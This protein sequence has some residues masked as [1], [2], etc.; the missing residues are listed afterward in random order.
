MKIRHKIAGV[1]L[2]FTLLFGIGVGSST[3]AKAQYPNDRNAQD[4]RDRNNR[5]SDRNRNDNG[6][7]IR[8]G[9][10]WDGYPNLGGTFQ[11]RQTAL[12]AGFNEGLKQ[13]RNDYKKNRHSDYQRFSAYQKGTSDYSSKLGDREL[14]RHYYRL[15][16]ENGYDAGVNGS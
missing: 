3:T 5:D 10:N 8:R 4:R 15:A 6:D 14:Y 12:N 11:L 16:Y 13:G 1:I 2:G 9:R 7:R